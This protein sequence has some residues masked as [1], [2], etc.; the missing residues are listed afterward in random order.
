MDGP[1]RG[2][3]TNYPR[4]ARGHRL[5]PTLYNGALLSM[6]STT[7]ER[8]WLDYLWSVDHGARYQ[9]SALWVGTHPEL[10]GLNTHQRGSRGLNLES[11]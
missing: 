7:L 2:R 3:E 5:A 8:Y 4:E 11:R 9:Y 10:L 6:L 1:R